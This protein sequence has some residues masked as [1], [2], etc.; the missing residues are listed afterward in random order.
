MINNAVN[1]VTYKGDGKA[2]EFAVTFNFLEKE[3]IV[4]VVIDPSNV[5]TKLEKDYFVD[6]DKKI[7]RYPGYSPG[8]EPPEQ[9]RPPILP[10]GW[11]LVIYRDIEITQEASLGDKWPFNVIEDSLDKETMIMQDLFYSTKRMLKLPESAGDDVETALPA[12][13]PNSSIFWDETGKKLITG[14]NPNIAAA[15]AE[16]SA[17]R[18][19]ESEQKAKDS[20]TNAKN[21][22][23]IASEKEV[24]AASYAVAA[25]QSEVN[26]KAS[27][28]K[29]KASETAAKAS[30][31]ASATSETNAK[32]SE[33]N[34]KAS[35]TNAK[36][37]E[38]AA[39]IS[40]QKAKTSETNAKAS[41]VAAESSME[42]AA[43]SET[44]AK[45]SETEAKIAE[46]EAKKAAQ[47]IGDP[48][49]KVERNGENLD[50]TKASGSSSS[51]QINNFDVIQL[52]DTSTGE[53]TYIYAKDG[54]LFYSDTDPNMEE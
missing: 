46:D 26:A 39:A 49:S 10:E 53:L 54:G 9:E 15:N 19:L 45:N 29:A 38:T 32:A 51:I 2:T 40:E 12:P 13:T 34:A 11:K 52:K 7:V 23:T 1:R 25:F 48:I 30:E 8:E 33:T 18:A 44:N 14:A 17:G 35:E 27:E 21:S 28:D 31:N 4:V 16:N 22:E 42:A 47:G 37:S 20:E 24:S 41:E 36:S 43:I 6:M 50:F 3:D 5:E